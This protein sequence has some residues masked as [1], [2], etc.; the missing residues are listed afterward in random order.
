MTTPEPEIGSLAW[1][2]QHLQQVAEDERAAAAIAAHPVPIADGRPIARIKLQGLRTWACSCL[3]IGAGR[4]D[5]TSPEIHAQLN[6][7]HEVT[8][9]TTTREQIHT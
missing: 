9:E 6:P 4:P 2:A 7:G 3:V 5:D 8:V 1:T